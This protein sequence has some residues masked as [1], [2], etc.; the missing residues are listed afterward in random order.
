[1]LESVDTISVQVGDHYLPASFAGALWQL[2][3]TVITLDE[4]AVPEFTNLD[5]SVTLSRCEPFWCVFARE[6]AGKN[7]IL[8]YNRWLRKER[9]FENKFYRRPH[10]GIRNSCWLVGRK[11][12]FAGIYTGARTEYER[13]KPYLMGERGAFYDS[14]MA[15]FAR[16]MGAVTGRR[17]RFST[18]DDMRIFDGPELTLIFEDLPNN[19]D[20]HIKHLTKDERKRRCWLGVEFAQM[21]KEMAKQ[22]DLCEQTQD[23][24]I[25]FII[26][27]VYQDSP[28]AKMGLAEGDV[29]L[30]IKVPWAPWLIELK[31]D[32]DRDYGGPDWE[33][34]DVPQ[35]F[36]AMGFRAP[37]K[38]PWP[39]RDNFFTRMLK[40]IGEGEQAQLTYVHDNKVARKDFVIEQSPRDTLSAE[41]YKDEKLGLTVKNITYE[42]RAAMRLAQEDKGIVI[43]KV[44]PGTP[45]AL[46]RINSFELI[47]AVDGKNVS[48]VEDF[49]KAIK[50]AKE[51]ARESVRVTVEW[52]GKT[53]LTDLKFEAKA[54]DSM[55]SMW[56]F[57]PGMG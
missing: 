47:R 14:G 43:S 54:E 9:G 27:R 16:M 2:E 22:M 8:D 21:S 30:K 31:Q 4:G 24:R 40:V 35:E 20:K 32:R 13:I 45:A 26:N 56:Q 37:R 1:L 19:Y 7:M 25:G 33:D 53:R 39:G 29:L 48:S 46:A 10:N 51:Q 18:Q 17:F 57:F 11:G 42:V 15:P 3:G 41:K 52:L 5:G 36:E 6:L 28:A 12:R 38:R 34:M 23:G 49:E 50:E 55:E 44:E